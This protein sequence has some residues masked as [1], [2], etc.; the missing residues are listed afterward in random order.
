MQR[1]ILL[2]E[3]TCN[4][5]AENVDNFGDTALDNAKWNRATDITLS[6]SLSR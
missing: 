2:P 4:F 3:I 6:I 1:F 5:E